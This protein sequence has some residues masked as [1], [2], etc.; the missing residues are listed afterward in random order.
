MYLTERQARLLSILKK[1]RNCVSGSRL[2]ELL[3]VTVRTVRSDINAIRDCC[4]SELIEADKKRGY[5]YNPAGENGEDY[6]E[7]ALDLSNPDAR[8]VYIL[9]RLI[10]EDEPVDIFDFAEELYVSERTI[11]SDLQRIRKILEK[12]GMEDVRLRRKESFVSLTGLF[13]T[14][15]NILYDVAREV[16]PDLETIDFQKY[17]TDIHIQYYSSLVDE[18][19]DRHGY[20]SRYLDM[21]RFVLDAALMIEAIYNNGCHLG[22]RCQGLIA[23]VYPEAKEQDREIAVEIRDMLEERFSI[24]Q[25]ENDTDYLTAI[26]YSKGKM[27]ALE[28]EIQAEAP[29]DDEFY[30]FCRRIIDRL[31]TE[32]GI[33]FIDDE[34]LVRGLIL[35]LRIAMKRAELGIRLYN[36]LPENMTSEYLYLMD[37]ADMIAEMIFDEYQMKLDLN[38]VSYIAVYLAAALHNACE[39]IS[40]G[41]KYRVFLYVPESRGNYELIRSSL[42]SLLD[43]EK[44]VVDGSSRLKDG[45]SLNKFIIDYNLII[46]T[47]RR[48]N[49]HVPNICMIRSTFGPADKKRVREL[50]GEECEKLEQSKLHRIFS[51]FCVPDLFVPDLDAGNRGEVITVLSDLLKKKGYVGEDFEASVYE[52]ERIAPT[53]LKSGIALPHSIRNAAQR[54]G[55]AVAILKNPVQWSVGRVRIV[56]MYA[57]STE[58][59][60]D[61]NMFT[62]CFMNMAC[63]DAFVEEARKSRSYDEFSRSALKYFK[64]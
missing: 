39:Q 11:E 59:N 12:L 42:T 13:S 16:S 53:D 62:K 54:K 23:A 52:R 1:E 24:L 30:R 34:E 3:G 40:S 15:A 45:E 35:H 31:R 50:V 2:S 49:L 36:P 10:L 51:E 18:I 48:L 55:M 57:H 41:T 37:L 60:E 22:D 29:S 6:I 38:E 28:K 58:P 44:V 61:S 26:L 33:C 17:F 8:L 27:E 9:K 7:A 32:K 5:R 43:K 20:V 64:L 21:T 46:T 14:P 63:E 47:S 56:C 25:D 4:G 19:M